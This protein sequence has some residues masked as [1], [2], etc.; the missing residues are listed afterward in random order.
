[1]KSEQLENKIILNENNE[2]N[3]NYS[4][5]LEKLL[6]MGFE[7]EKA[8]EAI[9]LSNG[10]MELAIEYLYNGIPKNNNN[11]NSSMDVNIG[12][13]DND[14]DE[15][16]NGEDF[17]DI[18]YLLKKLSSIFK[19]LTKEK[20]KTKEEILEII[21][22]Y[23][24]RLFQFIKENEDEFNTYLNSPLS[25]EDKINYDDFKNGKE[26]CGIYDLNYQ[27]FD[28]DKNN[29]NIINENIFNKNNSLGN[30]I[31]EKEFDSEDENINNSINE[32]DKEIIKRLTELGNFSEK[33]VI[34]AYLA[35]DKN[36]ELAANYLFETA[37][38][39]NNIN[40]INFEN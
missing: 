40:K 1:M 32:K 22:K 23:N 9:K 20:K 30:D 37:N 29:N 27:L 16:E 12:D 35:C 2:N 5:E 15:D 4:K 3:D 21:Q 38:N 17:E 10:K 19:F 36:E 14:D 7:K 25:Q 13:I 28:N 26:K 34:Q 31:I 33:E 11:Q 24:F 8:Y 6:E 18:T 39:I